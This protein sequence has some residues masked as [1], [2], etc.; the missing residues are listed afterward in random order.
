MV[1]VGSTIACD[2]SADRLKRIGIQRTESG[3]RKL[4]LLMCPR[5]GTCISTYSIRK[6]RVEASAATYA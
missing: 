5:C 3:I 6:R 4:Y 2:H 1:R